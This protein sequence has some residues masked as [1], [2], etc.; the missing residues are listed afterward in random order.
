MKG[1]FQ[2]Y[3]EA[4]EAA[5]SG[6]SIMARDSRRF[7]LEGWC[8]MSDDEVGEEY[9]INSRIWIEWELKRD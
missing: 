6:E 2:T 5:E 9:R 4:Y 7:H 8:V 3:Q 1:P